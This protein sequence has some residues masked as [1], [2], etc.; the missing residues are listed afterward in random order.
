ME[1]IDEI[2]P[3]IL[4]FAAQILPKMADVLLGDAKRFLSDENSAVIIARTVKLHS[5]LI[6]RVQFDSGAACACIDG[7]S[8]QQGEYEGK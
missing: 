2:L 6:E 8:K 4:E 1:I 5:F 7:H 3:L